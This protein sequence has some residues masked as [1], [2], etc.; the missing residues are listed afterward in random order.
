MTS[1]K[2]IQSLIDD[3]DGILSKAGSR[4][5]WSM[6]GDATRERQVLERVRSYLV[7]QQ[8]NRVN[9]AAIPWGATTSTSAEMAQ[10]IVQAV[11]QEMNAFR[12]DVIHPLQTDIQAL[13]QQRESLVQEIQQLERTKQEMD[14]P[15]QQDAVQQHFISEFAQELMNRCAASLSQQVAQIFGEWES[16][17]AS[18]EVTAPV[19]NST[20]NHRS[21]V[22]SLMSPQERL[23]QLRQLQLQSDQLLTTLDTDQRVIFEALQRN[24]HSYQESLSQ[25]LEKMHNLGAQGE[26]LFATLVNRLAQQLG[27]EA[28][29]LLNSSR[30]PD[31]PA[32]PSLTNR[33]ETLLPSDAFRGVEPNTSQLAAFIPLQPEQLPAQPASNSRT[34]DAQDNFSEI[35]KSEDWEIIEG[36]ELENSNLELENGDR[37]NNLIQL[38]ID[39]LASLLDGE[40]M[41]TPSSS[42]NQELDDLLRLMNEQSTTVTPETTSTGMEALDSSEALNQAAALNFISDRRRQEIDDLYKSLFGTDSL[43]N[44]TK[45]DESGVNS[46]VDSDVPEAN[47]AAISPTLED[48]QPSSFEGSNIL[49]SEVNNLLFEGVVDPSTTETSEQAEN[50]SAAPLTDSWEAVIFEDSVNSL[51]IDA[52][53]IG[54]MLSS[55]A[56]NGIEQAAI[57]TIATLT[58]L[59]EQM[60]LRNDASAIKTDLIASPTQQPSAEQNS[61]LEPEISIVEDKDTYIPASPE[62][63]LLA[64]DDLESQ[65]PD[66]EIWLDQ[67]TLQQLSED[68]HSFED[69]EG[70]TFRRQDEQMSAGNYFESLNVAPE[71]TTANQQYPQFLMSDELLAEDW[72]EFAFEFNSLS[73]QEAVSSNLADATNPSASEFDQEGQNQE[74]ESLGRSRLQAQDSVE[75][76]FDPDLFPS[77]SLELDQESTINAGAV[78]SDLDSVP[79]ELIALEDENEIVIDEMQW[80]E[81]TDSTTE[82]AIALPQLELNSDAVLPAAPE[83]NLEEVDNLKQQSEQE[84]N[85]ATSEVIITPQKLLP[86]GDTLRENE[87]SSSLSGQEEQ[88]NSANVNHLNSSQSEELNPNQSD[89]E[90]K[91]NSESGTNS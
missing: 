38:D 40:K 20:T 71:P 5:F 85:A 30:Q 11:A 87:Q 58:E 79:A 9:T 44:T 36:L 49:S 23:E 88:L 10:Q 37:L 75:L 8:Q 89:S 13:R 50:I 21:T 55:T 73:N 7:S 60:G 81:P 2:D 27:R 59:L 4:L 41:E 19:N 16:L 66:V 77:E 14:A 17:L 61:D 3:I 91:N 22:G 12:A 76:G 53:V 29:T 43:I 32:Q 51:P 63:D 83:L 52:A 64:T 68:L 67:N 86:P 25:G 33:P 57:Q 70:R 82:E 90:K 56:E 15:T 18:S 28:S 80:D 31:S 48:Y 26:M 6:P 65:D 72:E 24:L 39:P 45:L 84:N 46:P 62:E 42:D 69:A 35:L 1:H 74:N 54:D 34:A 47:Q 78:K